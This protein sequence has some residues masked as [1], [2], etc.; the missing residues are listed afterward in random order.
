MPHSFAAKGTVPTPTA[1]TRA[2]G[3]AVREPVPFAVSCMKD[4]VDEV[5]SVSDESIIRAMRLLHGHLGLVV[6][7]AGAAGLPP[8]L[9]Q[10]KR[11]EGAR[12]GI[13][14]RGRAEMP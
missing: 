5:V 3:I 12:P 8:P 2:D 10:P 14:L 9:E 11:W 6:E 4:T 7:P 13:P 1:N